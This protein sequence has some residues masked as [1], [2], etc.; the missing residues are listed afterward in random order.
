MTWASSYARA[1]DMYTS[2]TN[3]GVS[4]SVYAP[5]GIVSWTSAVLQVTISNEGP[6]SISISESSDA[7]QWR[8]IRMFG[9]IEGGVDIP[10]A[11]NTLYLW[12]GRHAS[13]CRGTTLTQGDLLTQQFMLSDVFDDP[14][15]C[16]AC[17]SILWQSY[18]V[19]SY[20]YDIAHGGVGWPNPHPASNMTVYGFSITNT[21]VLVTGVLV[22]IESKTK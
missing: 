9:N 21:Y 15:S 12:S 22:R 16:T 1:D 3:M 8:G 10:I 20:D 6:D 19:E 11:S 18:A 4:L 7:Y 13:G 2:I 14:G 17:V 5:T